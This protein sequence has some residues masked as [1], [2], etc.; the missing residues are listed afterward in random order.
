[1]NDHGLLAGGQPF[2]WPVTNSACDSPITATES[3]SIDGESP[4]QGGNDLG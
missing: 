2:A 1:M 4:L 3:S